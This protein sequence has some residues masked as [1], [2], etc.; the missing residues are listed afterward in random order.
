MPRLTPVD[1]DPFT[2]APVA[3]NLQEVDYDPFNAAPQTPKPQ[4]LAPASG[5]FPAVMA[6][7]PVPSTDTQQPQLNTSVS[8]PPPKATPMPPPGYEPGILEEVWSET[9][10]GAN[11]LRLGTNFARYAAGEYTDVAALAKDI[12]ESEAYEKQFPKSASVRAAEEKFKRLDKEGVSGFLP[13]MG[14]Y[15][16]YPRALMSTVAQSA[17]SFVGG[18]VGVP[19]GAAVG[20]AVGGPVGAAAGA[21]VGGGLGSAAVDFGDALKEY[22]GSNNNP[23]TEAEWIAVLT[24]KAKFDP[25]FN[26]AK[27][28]AGV[29]GAFAAL[30]MKYGSKIGAK[31]LTQGMTEK[32][33]DKPIA[34]ALATGVAGA[35]V[36]AVIGGIGEAGG[37]AAG[38]T[39][40]EG[41]PRL[42]SPSAV[43]GEIIGGLAMD[44]AGTAVTPLIER[45]NFAGAKNTPVT[46][47]DIVGLTQ[48]VQGAA[49]KVD[50]TVTS[51]TGTTATSWKDGPLAPLPAEYA[52]LLK[53]PNVFTASDGRL[54]YVNPESGER[55]KYTR[56]AHDDSKDKNVVGFKAPFAIN[57]L[58][59][60]QW[61][62]PPAPVDI[63]G[64]I[65]MTPDTETWF[66]PAKRYIETKG[67]GSASPDQW[68]ATLKNAPGVKQE[69]LRDIGF[70]N[71]MAGQGDKVTKK[72]VTDFLDEN[73][74]RLE[75]TERDTVAAP[76]IN[77]PGV[78]VGW[79]SIGPEL[80]A[81][82]EQY[83]LP[84]DRQGYYELTMHM[85]TRN[86]E[87]DNAQKDFVGGHYNE[88]NVIAHMRVTERVD[89]TGKRMALIEEIQ[90]DW[91]QQ[92]RKI[93]YRAPVDP[94][95]ET[96][97]AI[98]EEKITNRYYGSS[99]TLRPDWID[100]AVKDGV[101]DQKEAEVGFAYHKAL[102]AEISGTV[103]GPFKQSW[104][105]LAF[106]R[107]LKWAVERGF[108][109]VAWVHGA[110][111]SRRYS[112]DA[113]RDAGM[114]VFY[115]QKIPSIAKKWAKT[116]GGSVG[117]I[118]VE[119]QNTQ[120][121]DIP[122][123]GIDYI[124]SGLPL[125]SDFMS[126][127]KA[128]KRKRPGAT[129]DELADLRVMEF[130]RSFG[131][132]LDEL[133]KR[134]GVVVRLQLHDSGDIRRPGRRPE[135]ALGLTE[136]GMAGGTIHLNVK[137]HKTAQEAWATITHEFGH[138][139]MWHTYENAS[140]EIRT[141]VKAAHAEYL[142][143]V[144]H[145]ENYNQAVWK[146]DNA[147]V[148]YH[149][150]RRA[151]PGNTLTMGGLSPQQREYWS[152]FDEWFA[153]QVARWATTDR[154]A[155]GLVEKF[156]KGL[157]NKMLEVFG[158]A[159]KKF[160]LSFEPSKAM[161]DWLNSFMTDAA[162]FG[163]DVDTETKLETLI[164]NKKHTGPEETPVEMQPETVV[165]REGVDKLFNGRPPKEIQETLAYADKFNKIYKWML[166]I[167]Q[168]AQKNKHIVP[169]QEYT[170]TIAVAQLTK[171]QVMIRA[172]G[173]LKKWNALGTKQG[174]AVAALLDAIQNM[175]YL[176]SDEVKQKVSRQPTEAEIG[177]LAQKYNVSSQGIAVAK[178]VAVTFQEHLVRY[179][180]VLRNE[181]NKGTDPVAVQKR[182][183]AITAQMKTLR[184]KPY[185]PAMRFGDFTITVKN[186]AGAVI[187]FETFERERTRNA[188]VGEIKAKMA[189]DDTIQMGKL[190][191]AAR[192]LLGV[193]TQLLEMMAEKLDLTKAQRDALEQLK[194]ELSPAQS[195]K[196]RFQHKRRV[197]GYSQDFR[198]A[199][200][201][202]FFHGA[203]HLMKA[204]YA[205]RLRAL[206]KA[207]TEETKD[208]EKVTRRHEIVTFMNDHLENW[209][210]PKSDWAAIRSIA[211]FWALAWTPAAAAQNLTQTMMTTYPF[212][213]AQFGDLKAVGA[214]MRTGR[215]FETFYKKGT[216]DNATEF[217]LK[218]ISQGIKDGLI[219]EAM[220]PELA[221]YAENNTLGRWNGTEMQTHIM[222]F[223]EWGAKMFELAEQVNRRLAFRATLKL[224][225]EN[226][227]N[228]F[229]KE[230]PVKHRLHYEQL[231]KEG[232]TEAQAAAYVSARDTVVTTQFQ[233]GREYAP[234]FMRGKARSIFVF[235]TFIQS[236]VVFLVNY[237]Q[238]AVRSILVM[239]FLG[240]LMGIPGAEDLQQIL[241]ALGWR[242]FGK[243]FDLEKEARK[244]MLEFVG[245]DENGRQTADMV[246]N[247]IARQGYGIPAFM[248][249]IG[250]TVGVDVPM[251]T[252]D[253]SKAI[254]AGTLLPVELGKLF[255]P[256]VQDVDM[257]ISGQAQKA[258]GAV[259]GAGFN[260]YKALVNKSLSWDDSK[261]WEKAVPRALGSLA[262]SY[263]VGTEGRERT[264]TGAT[265]VKYDVRDTE[266]LMEV[267]GIAGG[268]QPFRTAL[269]WD[270]VIAGRDAVKLWDIR[271]E[272][273]MKQ[274]GNATF[275]QDQ[276]E[277]DRVRGAILEFNKSLPDAARGKAI[278]GD[279]LRASVGTQAR[280]RAAREAESSVRRSDIPI[281]QEV[282][283]LY[284]ASRAVSV[285]KVQ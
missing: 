241:K 99:P 130:G 171:Q 281:L 86:I 255:G 177:T 55:F 207:T 56:N 155:L 70:E 93:G 147:V 285:K 116:L 53:E 132:A 234:R 73:A 279:V 54:I 47:E 159:S 85:P 31:L 166:G 82:Y 84:G 208:V 113:Q 170:E 225:M 38:T 62:V 161:S 139:V 33:V 229:V 142:A 200:A 230:M 237:P 151:H 172:Q 212:L 211:F 206:T 111:Q 276:K 274:F 36:S 145:N 124:Q 7:N 61:A 144:P 185:F 10:K 23:K 123:A 122:Q 242:L 94:A 267:I 218:A 4:Q 100:Q 227:G 16:S 272:G 158:L 261:R 162:P 88:P 169:L 92:G 258:S 40:A 149:N 35:P 174:D 220:A 282:Q 224:A 181:A 168:V 78:P 150:T 135:N 215:D 201:S 115:D 263:R 192:P 273:L 217:E 250:G 76:E 275:G 259:F 157:A 108:Q 219:S 17:P 96:Q 194:F 154:K 198:R 59:D 246:L 45:T 271:R 266:Q 137:K 148:A 68:I 277:I 248:D 269:Q 129:I 120:Y 65:M 25:A 14:V 188:A 141:A 260:I 19:A 238:A 264:N 247:G 117:T 133:A 244:W 30:G 71:W 240:G 183:D 189:T 22:L 283:K 233:Y 63:A 270:R 153:E 222:K 28:H 20:G 190:D 160:N 67:P 79:G 37:Q 136:R 156:F 178:E 26:Y 87:E 173:V 52:A 164:D 223:N 196:H 134:F 102:T 1:Y 21:V 97:A 126:S 121:I 125:Y 95:L 27:W 91:H 112:G 24:D 107:M 251:P 128:S 104:D 80:D 81:K 66:S 214:L 109:R 106:K 44:T 203:N 204:M 152:G 195:F 12:M 163:K 265:L 165:I 268:Y 77:A 239:G 29:V 253:R 51:D 228:K 231:R 48:A 9:K 131:P 49:K 50:S 18:F 13:A 64:S 202:Y 186:A 226:P 245:H 257:V 8:A 101:I 167:H 184:N 180:A 235:K 72:E 57:T 105:E 69:E 175:D 249:M 284:P 42:P 193:P 114:K 187:H 176:T 182:Q 209:L 278:T 89:S 39:S 3:S 11:S 127:K 210:D 216:L 197:A 34:G 103:D 15:A 74:I 191:R 83:T 110:E 60:M 221:G 138:I 119:G 2:V 58:E 199:Y 254:S 143:T 179:E 46:P 243:D 146:R 32:L 236:Y 213:A 280:S 118:S 232:W 6:P 90:S 140:P 41:S 98:I 262:H 252:F 5:P 75:V 256:P 205:D 43:A